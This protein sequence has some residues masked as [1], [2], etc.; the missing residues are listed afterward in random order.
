M[1][2]KQLSE[3]LGYMPSTELKKII[4]TDVKTTGMTIEQCADAY[5]MPP[6][7]MPDSKGEFEHEGKRYT[8]ETFAA[9]FPHRRFIIIKT[10]DN[11]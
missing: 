2:K 10:D 4:L 6:M 11:D 3:L 5:A 8:S 7:F 1:N 9:Q